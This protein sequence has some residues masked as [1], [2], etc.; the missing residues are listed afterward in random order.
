ML[1]KHSPTKEQLA[2]VESWSGVGLSQGQMAALLEIDEKTLRKNYRKQ[3]DQGK[4]KA[5]A[6]VGKTLFQKAQGGDT[7]A[8]IWWTK[9]QMGWSEKKPMDETVEALM[10]HMMNFTK[11]DA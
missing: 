1:P 9:A 5:C 4:A 8:M 7:T 11:P 10:N 3:L 2:S 6:S